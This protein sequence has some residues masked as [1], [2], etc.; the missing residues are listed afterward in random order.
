M[1]N[2]D[3]LFITG[4]DNISFGQLKLPMKD[5]E[6]KTVDMIN[7]PWTLSLTDKRI[8]KTDYAIY[9]Q[10]TEAFKD[11][12]N[13]QIDP[14]NISLGVLNNSNQDLIIN[15]ESQMLQS[16]INPT[17]TYQ[18]LNYTA[19]QGFYLNFKNINQV[20]PSDYTGELLFTVSFDG[21]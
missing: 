8:N 21:I 9:V 12:N 17:N 2:Y 3:T 1:V 20:K 5:A 4:A 13:N 18:T 7:K 19:P 6:N 10:Q 15:Q 14:Y 11:V 16:Y